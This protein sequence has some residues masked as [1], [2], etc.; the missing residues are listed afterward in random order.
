MYVRKKYQRILDLS[1]EQFSIPSSFQKFITEKQRLHNL[2][3]KSKGKVCTCTYCNHQFISDAKVNDIIKCKNC[4]TNLLVKTER[5]SYYIFKDNLQLLDKV[6]D[7]YSYTYVLRTFELYTS[8]NNGTFK[9]NITEFMRTI[10]EDNKGIDF[11]SNQVQNH[12][13]Y[14][15]VAHYQT[16]T[17]WRARNYRWAYRDILGMVC[18]Y[19]LKSLLK[20]IPE[21]RYSN[22]DKFIKKQDDYLDFIGYFTNIAHYYSFE[23]LV[24][25]KLYNLAKDADEFRYNDKDTLNLLKKFYL[26]IKKHNLTYK[27]FEIL[28][29]IKKEDIKLINQLLPYNCLDELNNYVDLETAYNKVLSIKENREH[30]YLDYLRVCAELQYPMNDKKILYPDNLQV[31]HDKVMDILEIVKNEENDKLIKERLKTLNKNIYQNKKYIIFPFDSAN[32]V[33]LEGKFLHI[34]IKSY[35]SRYA[36]SQTTLYCL[37]EINN[38]DTPLI[39]VEVKDNKIIQARAKYNSAPTK[40]QQKFLDLWQNKILNKATT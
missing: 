40:E 20:D 30:E 10:I 33:I 3:I 13:G 6:E 23:L 32:S 1:D 5:L 26:F 31:Q 24:K 15:Y 18:S 39:S 4:K 2:I 14:M 34:C 27:Q 12:M 28:K 36:N 17:H 25:N 7:N 21:L 35:I 22:L 37:R 29:L 38:K 9:H 8:Y 19:N 16:R 11:V